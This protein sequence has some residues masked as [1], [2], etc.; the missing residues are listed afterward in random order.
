MNKNN[1][2]KDKPKND[3]HYYRVSSNEQVLGYSLDNQEKFCR[4]FS[5]VEGYKVFH[6]WREEGE[7]AKTANRTQLKLM[8]RFCEQDRKQISRVVVYKVD[9]LS[10]NTGDYFA[11][12]TFFNKLGI[13]LVSATEKLEDTPGGKFYETLLSAAAEFDNNVRSQ[14]TTEGMKARLM[15]GSWSSVAPWGYINTTDRL[16]NKIIAPH[17]ERAEAV[18]IMFEMYA[19]GKYTFEE[20]AGA[21]NKLGLKSRHG[22]KISKQL[23]SKIVV[24]PIYYGMIVVPKFGISTQGLHEPI[25][26][27]EL[28]EK[29]VSTKKGISDRNLPRTRNNIYY[30]LRGIRCSGCGGSISG[31]KSKGR[32]KYYEY[33]GCFNKSCLKRTS[34]SKNVF[35]K[36]FTDFLSDLTPNTVFFDCLEEAIRIAHKSELQSVVETERKIRGRITKLEES[37]RK[38]VTMRMDKEISS[39]E[40]GSYNEEFNLELTSLQNSLIA[41]AP[42]ELEIENVV[43]TG[44]EFLKHLPENWKSL[45]VKDLR[46]L[47]NLLF[48]QNLEYTYPGIQTAQL[49]PIY[50]LK[51]LSDEE[52][53]RLV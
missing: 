24:N 36:E 28:F 48:P 9:R 11:L 46:V 2:K 51:S 41:L 21:V 40:F 26:T 33:Y 29:S 4:G 5:E 52:N 8:M 7:S 35:E 49:S 15:G 38:L 6:T 13:T 47:R 42:P 34:I 31:G 39:D 44:I 23:V 10:R 12:K 43:K 14:R 18:K 27:K 19:T 22:M 30:P 16:N 37:K 20:I 53:N 1:M 17:P 45:E 3:L 50:K 25:I 32:T